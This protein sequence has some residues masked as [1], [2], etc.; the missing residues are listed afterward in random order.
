MGANLLLGVALMTQKTFSL[1]LWARNWLKKHVQLDGL[2][3][4]LERSPAGLKQFLQLGLKPEKMPGSKRRRSF[5]P[6]LEGLEVRIMPATTIGFHTGAPVAYYNDSAAN[7]QI[8]RTGDLSGAS[9]VE[10]Y[11]QDDSAYSGTDYSGIST[12]TL[13]FFAAN[14]NQETISI[15]LLNNP[16]PN[17][18]VDFDLFLTNP[19]DGVDLGCSFATITIVEP[20]TVAFHGPNQEVNYNDGY[21]NVEVDLSEAQ[22]QGVS[23]DYYTSDGSALS[24]QDYQGSTGTLIFQPW[25]TSQTISVPLLGYHENSDSN[26]NL[27]LTNPVNSY[28]GRREPR[29][30]SRSTNCCPPFK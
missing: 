28:L 22:D 3:A 8:D 12:G 14:E 20:P 1:W 10:V 19:S 6:Q 7:I 23:I 30:R 29:P 21:A 16:E 11:S 18:D 26:F 13:V 15:P 4:L 9:S 17:G 24:G 27:F 25:Q 5:Q 2:L